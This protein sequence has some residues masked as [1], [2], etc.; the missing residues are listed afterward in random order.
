M[1]RTTCVAFL[2]VGLAGTA[3]AQT[4][5]DQ[6][7]WL[8]GTGEAELGDRMK[9]SVSSSLRSGANS[10]VDQFR[11]DAG[12]GY[13]VNE[14]LAF[15][16]RYYLMFRDGYARLDTRDETRN[17]LAGDVH[18]RVRPDRFELSYRLRLQY[19]TYQYDPN[20]FHI[21]NR[22]GAAYAVTKRVSPYAA[23]ELI[24]LAS[25]N[26]EYRET[27]IYLG[28]DWRIKKRLELGAFYMRQMETNVNM[29]EEND[30]LGI[31]LTYTFLRNKKNEAQ[32]SGS[33]P[34]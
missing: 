17:R 29:P 2:L 3:S 22:F 1:F 8:E 27:R 33:D 18:L 31:G 30:I 19:T 4:V 34:D 20:H 6:K 26:A 28:V 24:Y 7:L 9:L 32:V 12:L 21:R 14:Y 13:R 11:I 25:P 10:G 5:S 23:L 16:G 15:A